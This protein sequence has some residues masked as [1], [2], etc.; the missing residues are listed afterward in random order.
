MSFYDRAQRASSAK[1]EPA[2]SE[3]T[4]L[5]ALRKQLQE[6]VPVDELAKLAS[7]NPE[8]ARN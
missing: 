4:L 6:I 7:E 5:P 1:A 8:R 3:S 2:T